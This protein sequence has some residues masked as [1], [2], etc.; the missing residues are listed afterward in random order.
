VNEDEE[1]LGQI[2]PWRHRTA[3]TKCRGDPR[4]LLVPRRFQIKRVVANLAPH[5]THGF[6]PTVAPAASKV[7]QEKPGG[8]SPGFFFCQKKSRRR[9][10]W[11]TLSQPELSKCRQP[12]LA[13]PDG[14]SSAA[15]IS[16]QC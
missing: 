3:S 7:K 11:N 13:P 14:T 12:K 15:A 8:G 2:S 16:P 1:E 4:N 6:P 5:Q 10:S 9:A